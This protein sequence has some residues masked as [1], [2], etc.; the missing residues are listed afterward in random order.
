MEKYK[1]IKISKEMPEHL[2]IQLYKCI[3]TLIFNAILKPH[4]KLPPI[5]KMA[6]FL[7]VN[8]VTVVNAYKLLEEDFLVYKKVGSGTFISPASDEEIDEV[9]TIRPSSFRYDFSI[10]SPTADLFP[11]DDFKTVLNEVLERD[12]G[13]AFGYQES[14]GFLPLR[15]SLCQ[16][17]KQ[18][19]I[20][21]SLEELQIISGAQQGIDL[22]SKAVL[23]YG[24]TVIVEAPT[25]TGAIASFKLKGA[26]IVEVPLLEDGI[27]LDCLE[28]QLKK[29]RVKLIYL[30]PNSQNPTGISYSQEKKIAVL[31]LAKQYNVWV[32]EDD[33]TADLNYTTIPPKALKV[34]DQYDKTIYIKS[35]SKVLMPGLRL[36]FMIVPTQ[37]SDAISLAKH[38]ADISTSG[39]IQRS[40]DLYIREGYWDRQM[41]VMNEIFLKRFVVMKASLEKYRI[42]G[43]DFYIPRGGYNFWLTMSSGF[44]AEE[45]SWRLNSLSVAIVPG[46]VFY[47]N[48]I[49]STSFRL[50]LAGIDEFD[51]E[52]GIK[53]IMQEIEQWYK[54]NQSNHFEASN[55]VL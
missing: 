49:K 37:I 33:Y 13:F 22:V 18:H 34:Y 11:V 36:G 19:D 7:D 35:F 2:Y 15:Q 47:H 51:I 45:L 43:V 39:L 50:S 32:I 5:R 17:L 29:T 48:Q 6:D 40:F 53:I 1:S 46:N 10:S 20:H 27:D 23:D 24:D 26:S 3:R 55:P 25:Y 54:I 38:S 28:Q 12:K 14:K 41:C 4:E 30:M 21:C 42:E 31:D 8:N 9:S 52:S 16:Y 44:S